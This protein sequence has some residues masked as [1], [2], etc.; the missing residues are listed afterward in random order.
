MP[1][2]ATDPPDT[3]ENDATDLSPSPRQAEIETGAWLDIIS[4]CSA[5]ACT[6]RTIQR[7]VARG[8]IQRRTLPGGRAE[9]WIAGAEPVAVGSTP[10]QEGGQDAR[11]VALA[12]VEQQRALI[13]HLSDLSRQEATPLLAMIDARDAEIR[14]LV[15]ENARLKA[16]LEYARR[17]LWQR[18]TGK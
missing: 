9:F 3:T 5:L 10:R 14:A 7:R 15:D 17:S 1:D 12:V 18:L 16:E 8:E 13:D 4:A 11:S 2:P 6:E